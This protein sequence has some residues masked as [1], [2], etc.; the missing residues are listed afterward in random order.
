MFSLKFLGKVFIEGRLKAKTGLHIGGSKEALEVGGIDLPV[1]KDPFGVPFIPGSS[2]RGKM[3]A[4]IELRDGKGVFLFQVFRKEGNKRDKLYEKK[5]LGGLENFVKEFPDRRKEFLEKYGS[6]S[7]EIKLTGAP[8]VCGECNICKLFGIPASEGKKGVLAPTRLIVRDAFL[9]ED[10]WEREF[11]DKA[12]LLE[13]P[14]TEV[15]Y[16]NSI[17]RL[18]SVANPRQ[19]ERVPAGARFDFEMSLKLLDES[20]VDLLKTLF[21]GMKLLEDDYLG[22]HGSRGYGAVKF[23]DISIR[24]RGRDY[25]EGEGEEVEIAEVPGLSEVNIKDVIGKVKSELRNKKEGTK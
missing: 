5:V 12:E 10:H 8:C 25:Y 15:K 2:L 18:T 11:K 23:E 19:V 7:I 13:L 3:R 22:G 6:Q 24:L 4:L 16:E 17:D 14:Y 21:E 20:D 1:V 9:D